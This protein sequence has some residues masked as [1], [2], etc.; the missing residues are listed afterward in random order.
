[1]T[2][3]TTEAIPNTRLF[4]GVALGRKTSKVE[5]PDD[6]VQWSDTSS[7]DSKT[8]CS[9]S[10][11]RAMLDTSLPGRWFERVVKEW[12]VD[13][14]VGHNDAALINDTDCEVHAH[15]EPSQPPIW[16]YQSIVCAS[17]LN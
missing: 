8:G 4:Q 16:K 15:E 1:M 2:T 5:I 7:E 13:I 3:P 9:P 10:T 12:S 11:R 14:S 6:E 17:R